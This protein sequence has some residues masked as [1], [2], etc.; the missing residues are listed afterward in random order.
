MSCGPIAMRLVCS[1]LLRSSDVRGTTRG[2]SS[3]QVSDRAAGS[4]AT[5]V[6]SG[7]IARFRQ[8]GGSVEQLLAIGGSSACAVSSGDHGHT[9]S[10]HSIGES[11]GRTTRSVD[12]LTAVSA[13]GMTSGSLLDTNR[14]HHH[15][16]DSGG[17]Q[18]P[19]DQDPLRPRLAVV[20]RGCESRDRSWSRP[21]R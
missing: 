19:G 8:K 1:R 13:G 15:D 12:E 20:G 6:P 11:S 18:E 10:S 2:S 17:G 5:S 3:Y 9:A 21:P 7:D 16:D 4:K 14:E